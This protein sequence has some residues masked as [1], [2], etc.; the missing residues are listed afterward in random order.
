VSQYV[1]ST[2]EC[3]ELNRIVVAQVAG[4]QTAGPEAALAPVLAPGADRAQSACGGLVLNNMAAIMAVYGRIAEAQRL[5]ERSVKTLEQIYPANDPVLLRPLQILAAAW[6]EQGKTAKA[7][8]VYKRMQSIQIRRPE[9]AALVHGTAAPLLQTEGRLAEAETEY[10]A[11]FQSWTDAGRGESAD[12][13]AILNSLASLYIEGQRLDDARRVLDR[14]LIIFSH[15]IDAV[16]M[17]RIKLL[18]LRGVLHAKQ[19]K[20]QQAEEDLRD[21][22]SLADR[23]PKFDSPALRSLLGAYAVVLRKNHR[24]KDARSIEARLA[25]LGRD[26]VSEDVVDVTALLPR[27]KHASK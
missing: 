23:E 24:G 6:F 7:R 12:A 9:D 20:W 15:A 22:L 10:I 2:A 26:H 21:A 16:A 25:A 14:A 4:G 18:H 11:A 3:V 19:G 1:P 27:P 17:D 13:G 8:E 5:A